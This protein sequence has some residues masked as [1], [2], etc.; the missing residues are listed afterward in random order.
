MNQSLSLILLTLVIASGTADA[1]T[2]YVSPKGDDAADGMAAA[3][4]WKTVHRIDQAALRPGDSVLFQRGGQWRERL[5][6]TASGMQGSPITYA[7]YGEGE[8]PR[9]LGS[10][11]LVNA[12]FKPAGANRYSYHL[13][14][15]ADSALVDH[16]F[17]TGTFGSDT[18]T[19]DG[20]T[21]PRTDGKTYTACTRGNEI[22][23]AGK[24]HLVFRHLIV[25]ETAG[26]LNDGPNQGYGFRIEGST[27]VLVDSCE[28]YRC[29][30]HNFA[31]I[32]S[33]GFVGRHLIA[34]Y[35]VPNMPGDNTA[36]VSYADNGAPVAACT[37]VWDDISAAHLENGHGG[38]NLMFVSHGDHQ[39][40]I[41]IANS[42]CDTKMSFM[43]APVSVK[44]LTLRENGSVENFGN[45]IIIDGVHLLD[46]SAIDQYGS[47]GTIQHCV[48]SFTPTGGGATGYRS[49]IVCRDKAKQNVIRFNTLITKD[50]SALC[51]PGADATVKWYGN[52]A[53]CNGTT[54]DKPSGKLTKSDLALAD[55]NFYSSTATFAGMS[56]TDWQAAGCDQH[57]LHGDPMFI[58][59]ASGDFHLRSGSPCI[60][61]FKLPGEDVTQTD[62]RAAQ[63]IGAYSADGTLP[64][65]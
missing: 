40:L 61:A 31:A 57:S 65:K 27:D 41:T 3:R 58:D 59:Q 52:I 2:Y 1:V 17:L 35:V 24:N 56:L 23:S 64:S 8:K 48:A 47:N 4:P 18:I 28:A 60:G 34:A 11:L 7:D 16:V 30:R 15:S 51:L 32:N 5:Q 45:G 21:D 19:I 26:Q 49:A 50:F 22:F 55:Y 44:D 53:L 63:N 36:Y 29:G 20:T 13:S 42:T 10:D 6:A 14:A 37:S 62:L 43:S 54:I 33:T 9:F 39:G 25:D 38:M 12:D 46:S